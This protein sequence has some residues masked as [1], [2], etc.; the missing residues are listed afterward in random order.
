MANDRT[1]ELRTYRSSPGNLAALSNRFRDHTLS[2]FAEH[3][4]GVTGFWI[5]P[6]EDDATTGHLDLHRRLPES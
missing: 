6:D 4:I 1:F 3:G 5:A 2:L